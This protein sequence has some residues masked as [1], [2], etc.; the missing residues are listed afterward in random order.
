MLKELRADLARYRAMGHGNLEIAGHPAF[1]SVFWYRFG[2]WIYNEGGP[3]LV[4]WPCKLFYPFIYKFL[5]AVMQMRLDP[6]AEIGPGLYISHSGGVHIHPDVVIG[7]N[8]NLTHNVTIGTSAMGRPGV[9]RIGDDV[10]IGTGAT[11]IG[12]IKVGSGAKIA[13]NTLVMNNVPSGATVMGVPGR[14]MMRSQPK[15]AAKQPA[16]AV[17][18]GNRDNVRTSAAG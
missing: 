5:E 15:E 4:R 10:Y 7:P 9:P 1:W 8:C 3:A 2:H 18:D 16:M 17:K 12:D 14:V 11:L 6:S 13:A